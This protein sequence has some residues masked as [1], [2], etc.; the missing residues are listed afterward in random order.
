MS[1]FDLAKKLCLL[2]PGKYFHEKINTSYGFGVGP[3]IF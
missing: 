1:T 3:V 2:K